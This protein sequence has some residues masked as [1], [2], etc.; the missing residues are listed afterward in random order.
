MNNQLPTISW[1]KLTKKCIV[2]GLWL[3]VLTIFQTSFFSVFKVFG[4]TPNLVLPAVVTAA[5][6]DRE[7]SAVITGLTGGFLIDALGSFGLSLSP[8]TYMLF[9]TAAAL[10]T[11]SVMNRSFASFAIL[12]SIFLIIDGIIGIFASR[13]VIKNPSAGFGKLI[14]ELVFPQFLASLLVGIAVYLLTKLIWSRLFD[15]REMEG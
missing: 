2:W 11:F 4:M 12:T 3:F 5:I 7:R 1:Q 10:L 15:N 9:G 14:G 8:L 13:A 6:Y